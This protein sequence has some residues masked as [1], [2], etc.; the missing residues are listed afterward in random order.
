ME[1][2]GIRGYVDIDNILDSLNQ[3][4][5]KL[6]DVSRT[7]EVAS[8][9]M[10]VALKSLSHGSAN[11]LPNILKNAVSEIQKDSAI[12]TNAISQSLAAS[13]EKLK[14]YRNELAELED[15]LGKEKE[16]TKKY[17]KITNEINK[18]RGEILPL[19]FDVQEASKQLDAL[20]DT[21]FKV[22]DA[23]RAAA[24]SASAF[25]G[26]NTDT[27]VSSIK[28][29]LESLKNTVAEGKK[30]VEDAMSDIGLKSEQELN[31]AINAS[32]DKMR[33]EFESVSRDLSFII[34]DKEQSLKALQ[35]NIDALKAER[36]ASQEGS[37][38][39]QQID[40]SLKPLIEL[41]D[42]HNKILTEAKNAQSALRDE[43][44]K[45]DSAA[46]ELGASLGEIYEGYGRLDI[47]DNL[48]EKAKALGDD[49]NSAMDS[50][51]IATFKGD[52]NGVTQ[53]LD[54]LKNKA[55]ERLD[56]MLQASEIA[57]KAYADEQAKVK[58][59]ETSIGEL[60]D[61]LNQAG[62]NNDT[63]A[64]EA[65]T[66]QIEQQ[67]DTL[68]E[69]KEKL[70]EYGLALRTLEENTKAAQEALDNMS[71]DENKIQQI[72]A[73]EEE[74][75]LRKERVEV[76]KEEAE[77]ARAHAE[78]LKPN[79][80]SRI[81]VP[82][83]MS[84]YRALDSE[85]TTK[86]DAY[87]RE[88]A[89]LQKK[90]EELQK[91]KGT[92]TSV[93]EAEVAVL[94]APEKYDI[95]TKMQE[96]IAA[97]ERKLELMQQQ[98]EQ[99]SILSLAPSGGLVSTE[100]FDTVNASIEQQKQKVNSLKEKYNEY[101]KSLDTTTKAMLKKAGLIEKNAQGEEDSAKA[102]EK[103][104]KAETQKLIKLEEE[105]DALAKLAENNPYDEE[106]GDRIDAINK[107][108]RDQK[109]YLEELGAQYKGLKQDV[110]NV[111]DTSLSEKIKNGASNI[112]E[113]FNKAGTAIKDW[114]TG[115]GKF[116]EGMKDLKGSFELLPAPIGNAIK[117]I[118]GMTSAMWKMIRTPV[119]AII[120]A[121]VLA[122][123]AVFKWFNKTKEGQLQFAKLSAYIGSVI[124]SLIDILVQLGEYI[125]HAFTDPQGALFDF[126][127]N[128]V[129]TIKTAVRAA[130][131]LLHG[132][133]TMLQGVWALFSDGSDVAKAKFEEGWTAIKKGVNGAY[134]AFKGV[135]KTT[136]SLWKGVAR[137]TWDGMK[138]AW[139]AGWDGFMDKI[140]SI[141]HSAM[142]AYD[143]A[144]VENTSENLSTDADYDKQI[145]QKQKQI[146]ETKG[147][148]E[149]LKHIDELNKL[150]NEKYDE[151]IKQKNELLK[152]NV[153]ERLHH[154]D[155]VQLEA[156]K[157]RLLRERE[158]IEAKRAKQQKIA[159]ALASAETRRQEQA[160]KHAE[161]EAARAAR[162]AEQAKKKQDRDAAAAA[163]KA[164][165]AQKKAQR[166]REKADKA[167]AAEQKK[168]LKRTI[169][170][171]KAAQNWS[172]KVDENEY[173]YAEALADVR[174]RVRSAEI[175]AMEESTEKRLLRKDFD[176]AEELRKIQKEGTAAINEEIKR[177]Q[178][179]F[180]LEQTLAFKQT[181]KREY[182]DDSKLD[183]TKIEALTAEYEKLYD[184][185]QG[186]Q[187]KNWIKD[188]SDQYQTFADKRLKIEQ[189]YNAQIGV[190]QEQERR[191]RA[192]GYTKEAD[193]L[194]RAIAEA[195]KK[196]NEAL[197][198]NDFEELKASPEYIRAFEDLGNTSTETLNALIADFEKVKAS[199]AKNMSPE[200]LREFTKTLQQMYDEVDSR[201]S[202][203]ARLNK[204]MEE[205]K[206]ATDNV[207]EAQ[208]LLS[209]VQSGEQS[210]HTIKTWRVEGTKLVPVYYTLEEAQKKVNA[211]RDEQAK[212]S[213][214]VKKAINDEIKEVEALA[215]AIDS[216]GKSIGG[217]AGDIL[218]FV[219]DVMTFTTGII[220][221]VSEL[222][223]KAASDISMLEKASVILGIVS[224]GIKL[225]QTFSKLL[226]SQ[227]D[228]YERAV[229]K[230][231]EINKMRQTIDEYRMAVIKA[232]QAERNWL[233]TDNLT[234]LRDAWEYHAEAEKAYANKL[235]EV[236]EKY[237]DKR[238]GLSKWIAP[239]V[240]AVAG[241]AAVF[242]G[243]LSLAALGPLV[244]GLSSGIATGITAGVAAAGGALVGA[245][246]NSAAGAIQGYNNPVRAQDN[247]R[248][249]T[250]HKTWFRSE[251]T[252][253]L[254]QWVKENMGGADLFDENGL[255][256][257]VTAQKVLDKYG[258]KLVGETKDTLEELMELR[259][260]YD[261]FLEEIHD[262]VSD[263]F[264]P[265][266]DNMSDAVW[267]WLTK[268]EDALDKFKEYSSETFAD[269]A[270]DAIRQFMNVTILR[271]FQDELEKLYASFAAGV[272][273]GGISAEE[274]MRRVAAI[275]EQM[276]NAYEANLP[277]AEQLANII[278]S[279]FEQHGI[280]ITGNSYNED[281][282]ATSSA[283]EKITYDQA[284]ILIGIATATQ[285]AVEQG[286][287]QRLQLIESQLT[288]TESTI[289]LTAYTSE[290]NS[291]VNALCEMQASG[292]QKLDQIIL[293]T[294]PIGVIS[295]EVT[296][297]RKY[298]EENL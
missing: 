107:A 244:A 14:A 137:M 185:T 152:K 49:I 53:A 161:A 23:L 141:H 57:Q 24:T 35:T 285:I 127:N 261:K 248:I 66:K 276:V 295:S 282:G 36:D 218:G 47:I 294:N 151:Q 87:A 197:L 20:T 223:K 174:S 128:L 297:L 74:I 32:T 238:A 103:V 293:N 144:K 193:Q 219:A 93:E 38:M 90:N 211:A 272:E 52:S 101:T 215:K 189:D 236:Q 67:K 92:L 77:E 9:K 131:D 172:I 251:K 235:N 287:M 166:E 184:I 65:Y 61:K 78:Y 51:S 22:A 6:S 280:D 98:A 18:L 21:T 168:Q 183:T 164:E 159:L 231:K 230:Q 284:D 7:T 50:F 191:A 210:I 267:D 241:A 195:Q 43:Y 239:I 2:L 19:S 153:L 69:E 165:Q 15:S 259:E 258:D 119:G 33:H 260:E 290:I 279:A 40:A 134:N 205:Y 133:G 212:K 108:Y 113:G 256:D 277:A 73:L 206:I 234:S 158:Q 296:R 39:W 227:E 163:R 187:L 34:S 224:A 25:D 111:S 207:R 3:L 97:E 263:M 262:Y 56:V 225:V 8:A 75:E 201:Q 4:K 292:L 237:Q 70:E 247:L 140:N 196:K 148:A 37:V 64:I 209:R 199:A 80:I 150:I 114:A 63:T 243:G 214:K 169:D 288:L 186:S 220:S 273:N 54:E 155:T 181:G 130:G 145:A 105:R 275:S 257:L 216:V 283:A 1:E 254:R 240:G 226:P 44:L 194:V 147:E 121:L 99:Q 171:A 26:A 213:N 203:I 268:G 190:M 85:A 179:V 188:T 142:V 217:I 178:E 12:L 175:D 112:A 162:K 94:E 59:L 102:I 192:A 68:D 298:I 123:Q 270:K 173:K 116:Q 13:Q 125:F 82:E 28:T 76:L 96:E 246:V 252:A 167:L 17:E 250:R 88:N 202:T 182:W 281:Q 60:T 42:Q 200:Q 139:D 245:A 232:Q 228:Y 274:L 117:G 106:L 255:I 221:T 138:S 81:T 136:V 124:D 176:N 149:A 198:K 289:N 100:S 30:S 89:E 126:G 91:I 84:E 29:S 204:A 41:Y 86:E 118:Q 286:N 129:N 110:E 83:S 122:L 291:N 170:I 264:S 157:N 271:P 120:A 146:E 278:N 180:E 143:N 253:D 79:A 10:D 233:A 104:I 177:Q 266:L 48:R 5:A 160:A 269:I 242:T 109:T 154:G 71:R 11:E 31:S 115:H 208:E 62:E 16:G 135:V 265:L 45:T 229:A 46:S 156:E 222:A 72:K 249:Q 58:E 95:A 132:L 27:L 55:Q